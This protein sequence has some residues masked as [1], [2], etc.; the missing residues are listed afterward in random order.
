MTDISKRLDVDS[1]LRRLEQDFIIGM[2]GATALGKFI[3]LPVTGLE[4]RLTPMQPYNPKVLTFRG[5]FDVRLTRECVVSLEDFEETLSGSFER[6]YS[7]SPSAPPVPEEAE[8][9]EDFPYEGVSLLEILG[10]ELALNIT[11]FPRKPGAA[12]PNFEIPEEE[13]EEARPNPFAVLQGLKS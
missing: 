13:A 6:S 1:W 4:A 3:D 2:E 7:F 5:T 11:P 8:E 12:A 9:A 10:D